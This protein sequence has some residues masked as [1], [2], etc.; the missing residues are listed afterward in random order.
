[1][2]VNPPEAGTWLK[3]VGDVFLGLDASAVIQRVVGGI[4]ITPNL[5]AQ[6]IQGLTWHQFVQHY[7]DQ[8]VRGFRQGNANHNDVR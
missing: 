5:S 8:S 4:E 2:S 3:P 6:Q 7:A 1:M